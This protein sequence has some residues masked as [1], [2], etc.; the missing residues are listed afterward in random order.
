MTPNDAQQPRVP[1]ITRRQAVTA[2]GVGLTGLALT[3]C[4]G[5][6]PA[7]AA[8]SGGAAAPAAGAG[9]AATTA[10]PK[11]PVKIKHWLWLD[12]PDRP[13][14][15]NLVKKFNETHQSVQV[16]IEVIAAGSS[17]DKILA[18]VN[19]GDAPDTCQFTPA[20]FPAFDKMGAIQYLD[21][22]YKNWKSK[23]GVFPKA[24]SAMRMGNDKSPM[25]AVPWWMLVTY[26][27]YRKDWFRDLGLKAP[28]TQE[29]FLNAAKKITDPAR[30]RYGYALRGAR[31]GHSHYFMLFESRGGKLADE[32]GNPLFDKPEYEAIN[33]WYLDLALVHKVVPPTAPTDGYAE[34]MNNMKA[35]KAAMTFHH[36]WSSQALMESVGKDNLG[37][38][39]TPAGPTGKR[40]TEFSPVPMTMFKST[41]DKEAAWTWLS[42]LLEPEQQ[43]YWCQA[44]GTLPVQQAV[45]KQE[46]YQTNPFMKISLDAADTWNIFPFLENPKFA[47]WQEQTWP[48]T[49]Q[50]ALT[51]KL[52]V[53]G[54]GKMLADG[55]R[56]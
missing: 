51:G 27:Y 52:D 14:I 53:K 26:L 18:A 19:A 22:F 29:D 54:F 34:I 15:Q 48:A 39:M 23:D 42:W 36:V 6:K 24:V 21:D 41:R 40:W 33:Q 13:T 25:Y 9:A 12:W 1:G 37:A 30:G 47:K 4:G 8:G 7:P 55:L 20:W 38:V 35:A 43:D 44:E 45:A 46:F 10:A 11:A 49:A 3:A 50:Q 32:Q 56:A 16:E 31:H 28:E 17:Y 5:G 2:L